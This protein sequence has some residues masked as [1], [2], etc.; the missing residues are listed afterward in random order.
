MSNLKIKIKRPINKEIKKVCDG[1]QKLHGVTW[2]GE[3]SDKAASIKTHCYYAMKNCQQSPEKLKQLLDN[4]VSH[5]RNIHDQCLPTSRCKIDPAYE[6]SKTI[7]KDTRA[8]K[9]LTDA[10]RKLQIY[11]TPNDYVNCVDTHYVESF[12]NACLIYHDKRIVFTFGHRSFK[13]SSGN[14]LLWRTVATAIP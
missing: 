3:L 5:Y 10:I 8:I 13:C 11:K 7:L 9:L 1:R 14:I 4:I 6:P 2:H 12:N